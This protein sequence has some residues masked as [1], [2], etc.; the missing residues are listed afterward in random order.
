MRPSLLARPCAAPP[1]R[2]LRSPW[3]MFSLWRCSMAVATS[4]A[5]DSAQSRRDSRKR[6][7]EAA[8][9]AA[10][11]GSASMSDSSAARRDPS[12]Q[13]CGQGVARQQSGNGARSGSR[14]CRGPAGRMCAFAIPPGFCQPHLHDQAQLGAGAG[15]RG[16]RAGG[17]H[18]QLLPPVPARRRLAASRPQPRVHRRHEV[19]EHL[20]A[21]KRGQRA[22]T[23][24]SGMKRTAR[25]CALRSL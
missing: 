9:S 21:S 15:V 17:G 7:P 10:R 20:R 3:I 16:A 6:A 8:A 13:Y 1:G 18:Q 11:A 25:T 12:S 23:A 4:C 2:T 24:A 22:R 5:S 19:V 14:P